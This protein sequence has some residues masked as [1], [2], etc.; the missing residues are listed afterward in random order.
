[1]MGLNHREAAKFVRSSGGGISSGSER[2]NVQQGSVPVVVN[3][4]PG[5][6]S[7]QPVLGTTQDP[8]GPQPKRQPPPL[9]RWADGICDWPSNLFPS[10]YCV[11][12]ACHGCWLMAQMGEKMGYVRF[13]TTVAMYCIILFI[14]IIL[15][16]VFPD[17]FSIYFWPQLFIFIFQIGLRLYIV[18]KHQIQE[19]S[20]SPGSSQFGECCWGF[21]CCYCSMCQMARYVY[22]YD[23]VFRR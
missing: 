1:M 12:F 22:G 11:C 7:D 16:I 8:Y 18:R 6:N 10:A 14:S 19:C 21:W 17:S 4:Q 20:T 9:G 13:K 23:K 3:Q 2:Q 5:Y 15:E